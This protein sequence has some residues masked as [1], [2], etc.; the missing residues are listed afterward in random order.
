MNLFER[1]TPGPTS[2]PVSASHEI[3]KARNLVLWILVIAGLI[4]LRHLNTVPFRLKFYSKNNRIE[5]AVDLLGSY[6][7]PIK[8]GEDAGAGVRYHSLQDA[9]EAWDR[10]DSPRVAALRAQEQAAQNEQFQALMNGLINANRE[11]TP[12]DAIYRQQQDTAT[13]AQGP[14]SVMDVKRWALR[15]NG[16]D[17]KLYSDAQ[18]EALADTQLRGLVP[19]PP[20]R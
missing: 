6:Y 12:K 7:R 17:D 18:I 3:R 2:W 9:E 11:R 8:E 19:V 10:Y 15:S 4:S 20:P 1:L 5:T 14:F 16:V 13:T